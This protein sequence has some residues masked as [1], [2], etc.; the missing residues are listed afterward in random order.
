MSLSLSAFL[1]DDDLFQSVHL[2]KVEV[3]D[4]STEEIAEL[5]AQVAALKDFL[6]ALTHHCEDRRTRYANYLSDLSNQVQKARA[7]SAADYE[8]LRVEQSSELAALIAGQREEISRLEAQQV[9]VNENCEHWERLTGELGSV[10]GGLEVSEIQLQ[11]ARTK[12]E[13]DE[14]ITIQASKETEARLIA[15]AEAQART[16]KLRAVQEEIA[17]LAALQRQQ[18]KLY[19]TVVRECVNVQNT[20]VRVHDGVMRSLAEEAAK[21][22]SIFGTHLEIVRKQLEQEKRRFDNGGKIGKRLIDEL[23]KIKRAAARRCGRQLQIAING[24]HAIEEFLERDSAVEVDNLWSMTCCET[25]ER[26][27]WV[28]SER[29]RRLQREIDGVQAQTAF[30]TATVGGARAR[31][32]AASLKSLLRYS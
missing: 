11:I 3:R 5:E 15:E 19:S 21:R 29:V 1:D 30:A 24:T 28:L 16:A 17:G 23:R 20:I 26:D 22:D 10:R 32:K 25:A 14:L 8:A 18:E 9:G 31:L 6:Q 12:Q 13:Q 7:V 27:N 2:K 4:T